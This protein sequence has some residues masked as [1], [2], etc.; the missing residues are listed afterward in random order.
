MG[1]PREDMLVEEC[2]GLAVVLP[3]EG[4]EGELK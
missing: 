3:H 4:V 1:D 2:A